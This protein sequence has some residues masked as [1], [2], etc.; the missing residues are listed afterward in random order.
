MRS[1]ALAL[2]ALVLALVGLGASIA[3][4][5]D[6]LAPAPTF[7]S[8]SGCAT[9]RLSAWA[10]PLGIPLP[11][12][13]IAYFIAMTVLAFVPRKRLRIGLAIVG[14][15]GGIALILIQAISI[16]AWC[17][18]CLVVD[19]AAIAG[20]LV[21]IAG[22][23]TMRPTWPNLVA[24]LPAVA[25]VVLAL[26]LY[27]HRASTLVSNE[28]MPEC[29]AKEQRPG[30]VTIVEFV[31][32]QCPFC[33]A[34]DKTLTEALSRTSKPVRIV[35][36]MMPLR[37]HGFAVPAAMAWCSADAQGKGDEM[38]KELFAAPPETMTPA[39]CEAL[40]VKVGC[41]VAKYRETF[42][43]MELQARIKQ[44]MA[45]FEAAKLNGLP[46]IFIGAQKFETSNHTADALLAAIERAAAV[47]TN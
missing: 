30:T 27:S 39:G 17:K 34:L 44:D 1:R 37:S 23:G 21:V 16:G 11:I 25:L 32:F 45:D 14:G 7:C 20:A 33:R 42:A 2:L 28:P 24:T 8:E 46:T 40:A 5:V 12:V 10:T 38:A 35:R 29:V 41:D 47:S 31:D 26:G 36:K 6:Y 3:S 43:S 18:L 13:G 19:P 22:A 9:V 15:L 4:L